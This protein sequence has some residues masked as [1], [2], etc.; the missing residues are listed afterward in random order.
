MN[1]YLIIAKKEL[2]DILR[3]KIFIF[4][5]SLFLLLVTISVVVSSLVFADQLAQYMSSFEVLKSL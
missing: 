2:K 1:S 3:S 5:L 4:T